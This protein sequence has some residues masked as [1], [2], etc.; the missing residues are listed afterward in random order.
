MPVE[1]NSHSPNTAKHVTHLECALCNKKFNAGEIHNLCDCGGPLLVRY[2]LAAIRQSWDRASLATA[3]NSMWRYSPVLPVTQ[4]DSI[5]S[6]GEGMT[7][8]LPIPR[9]GARLSSSN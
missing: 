1:K 8:L 4:P 5:I 7:P 6:L 3:A 2:D 9:A